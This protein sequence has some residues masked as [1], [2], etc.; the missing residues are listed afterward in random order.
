MI[1][2]GKTKTRWGELA[3]VLVISVAVVIIGADSQSFRMPWM[4]SAKN[5]QKV[6]DGLI[7]ICRTIHN[8]EDSICVAAPSS[9][10]VYVR[11]V[12]AS[13]FT[14]YG[15]SVNELGQA[16][17]EADS[18]DVN[19][20]MQNAGQSDCD[21][22]IAINNE[23]ILNAFKAAGY[24]PYMETS[25]YLVYGVKGVPRTERSYNNKRQLISC[26]YYDAEGNPTRSEDGYYT[27]CYEYDSNGDQSKEYYLDL[28]G[29]IM[30]CS[31]GYAMIERTYYPISG[32]VDTITFKDENGELTETKDGYSKIVRQYSNRLLVKELFY[33]DE[34]NAI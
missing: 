8:E 27:V 30:M 19:M 18:P 23:N 11:Q 3:T 16:L 26:S 5:I 33:D 17:D 2:V 28:D 24:S 29:K 20:I 15:R 22:I 32:L 12:D 25:D 10:S 31:A 7:E 9:L 14:P 4:Q 6:P 13:L 1:V 21:Y 34:G